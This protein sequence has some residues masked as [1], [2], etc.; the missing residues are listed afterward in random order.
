MKIYTAMEAVIKSLDLKSDD[1]ALFIQQ[2]RR[3]NLKDDND[4]LLQIFNFHIILAKH[5]ESIPQKCYRESR[6]LQEV[7]TG[8]EN[9]LVTNNKQMRQLAELYKRQTI[10]SQS[11]ATSFEK[12]EQ[13]LFTDNKK[14]TEKCDMLI[15]TKINKFQ[16]LQQQYLARADNIKRRSLKWMITTVAVVLIAITSLVL[17][18]RGYEDTWALRS[19]EAHGVHIE[20]NSNVKS[21]IRFPSYPNWETVD[22]GYVIE[23]SQFNMPDE[24]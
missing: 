16:E 14:R 4:I 17:Y 21:C 8:L 9:I 2:L 12:W 6:A 20:F 3:M 7:S 15:E 1:K 11:L 18:G 24:Q 13:R 22:N 23:L 5:C 19:L 10:S